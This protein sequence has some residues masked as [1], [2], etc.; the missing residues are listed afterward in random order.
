M[1]GAMIG[2]KIK[3][4]GPASK[5][6]PTTNKKMLIMKN[7]RYGLSVILLKNS[8]I[9]VE[10]PEKLIAD[11]KPLAA[12]TMIRIAAALTATFANSA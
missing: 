9:S 11:A 4:A 2:A 6:I 5:N 8:A 10:I 7:S 1:M 12:A 3:I